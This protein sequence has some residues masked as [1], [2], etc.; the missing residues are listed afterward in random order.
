MR[1]GFVEGAVLFEEL[2]RALYEAR[3]SPPSASHCRS[4]RRDE[5]LVARGE[6]NGM[7]GCATGGA[8]RA[9]AAL[10][11]E[12]VGSR[13]TRSSSPSSTRVARAVRKEDRHYQAVS[14]PIVDT[15]VEVEL[16]R[17]LAYWAA[18]CVA[19]DDEQATSR[20]ARR[21]RRRPRPPC[22]V[23][24]VDPGAR[25]HRL[26]VGAPAAPL[27]QA[28]ARGSRRAAATAAKQRAEIA[29][30]LC[31]P[32]N[33]RVDGDRRA[34][35][36]RFAGA[37]LAVYAV[38]RTAGDA[39]AGTERA[40]LR[41]HRRRGD[42]ARRSRRSALDGARRQRGHRDRRA[43]RVPAAGGARAPARRERRR[44]A[45]RRC[46]RSCRRCGGRGAASSDRLDRR[47]V[48]AAVPRRL[49]DVEVRA[50]GDGR[51]AARRARAVRHA[52]RDRRAGDDRDADLDEAAA[53][54][55]RV[56]ARG[57][58]A[59]RCADRRSSAASQ[60]ARAASA[61]RPRGREG[62]RARATA[63]R[64]RTRYV[65]G[66]DAKR[67]RPRSQRAAPTGARTAC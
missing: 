21:S 27:L 16:A 19:E 61:S 41:R 31:C 17:S 48:G 55:R 53:R 23:R 66:P 51:L 5:A 13:S 22:R 4:C 35:A 45:A 20:C 50:R 43:A 63:P 7:R 11:L 65:V 38:V 28:G 2:G 64:P 52:R 60:R 47:Q 34:C 29:A 24:A 36:R 33:R 58:G 37:R 3:T 46:R 57:G 40:R 59:L 8:K 15:Y 10:A 30:S 44:P 1:L 56:P 39:P 14:H 42:R 67:R 26:H 62:G 6:R 9:L 54:G 32:R 18:W 49:R 25:R 12:A